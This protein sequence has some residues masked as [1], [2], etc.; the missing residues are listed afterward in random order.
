MRVAIVGAGAMG[1][2]LAGLLRVSP[3]LSDNDEIWLVG[4]D[5]TKEHLEAIATDGLRFE[6]RPNVAALLPPPILARL[7][8]PVIGLHLTQDPVL[9]YPCDLAVVLVKSYRTTQAG[10]Q[11]AHLLAPGGLVLSLQNGLGNVETLTA[12]LHDSPTQVTHGSSLLGASLTRPGPVVMGGLGS[13]TLG[14]TPTLTMA[15]RQTLEWFKQAMTQAGAAVNITD[16]VQSII[17]GKLVVNCAV[18]PIAALLDVTNGTLLEHGATRQLLSQVALEVAAVARAAHITLPFPDA[19]APAQAMRAAQINADNICSMVQDLRK[20]RPT[21]IE[22]INGAVVREA[23]RL[24]L[25][26]PVN[27]TLTELIRAREKLPGA[28]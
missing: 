10:Q 1:S 21:E 17:W 7:Q 27:R 20:H 25:D 14:T 18:N 24:G 2:L 13:T 19:E 26:V 16:N 6:V 22:A 4:G 5:S 23:T 28:L 12:L 11:V 3:F 15:H 8:N 9:A